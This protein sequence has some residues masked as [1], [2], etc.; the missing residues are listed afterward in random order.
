MPQNK[1][2]VERSVSADQELPFETLKFNDMRNAD[3]SKGD[4]FTHILLAYTPKLE[5]DQLTDAP[6][7]NPESMQV[8]IHVN[9]IRITHATFEAMISEFSGR[10]LMQRV[11][12]AHLDSF[13]DAVKLKA[14]QL[15]RDSIGALQDNAYKLA[16]NLGHLAD[17][18]STIIENVWNAPYQH[19]IDANM[20]RAGMNAIEHFGPVDPNDVQ[21]I[22]L[23][24]RVYRAMTTARPKYPINSMKVTLPGV[25]PAESVTGSPQADLIAQGRQQMLDEVMAALDAQGILFHRDQPPAEASDS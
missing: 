19:C 4:W 8:T 15:L 18:S 2:F 23:A 16:E 11:Q 17:Q 14:E 10:M 9:D 12:R 22:Q 25:V 5:L 20:K 24:E 6:G 13:E 7:F 1:N 3:G 21:R